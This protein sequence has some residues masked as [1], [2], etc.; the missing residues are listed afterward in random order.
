MPTR[1]RCQRVLQIAVTAIILFA[2]ARPGTALTAES[3]QIVGSGLELNVASLASNVVFVD[4]MKQATPWMS[5]APLHLDVNGN[6]MALKMGQVADTAIYST[7]PYPPGDYTLLYNGTGSFAVSSLSG[8]IVS[9]QPGRLTIRVVPKL[10]YGIRLQLTATDPRHYPTNI[11]LILPGYAMTYGQSPFYAAFLRGLR[12]F[13]VLRFKQWM[14]P[15]P[16]AGRTWETRITS[17]SFTQAGPGGASVEAMVSLANATGAN[18]WFTLPVDASDEYVFRFAQSVERGLDPRLRPIFEYGNEVWKAG[19][20][21]NVYAMTAGSHLGFAADPRRAA[22]QWYAN[23]S[24]RVFALVGSAAPRAL[25]ILSGPVAT[26]GTDNASAA[27]GILAAADTVRHADAFAIDAGAAPSALLNFPA[28][29]SLAA[30]GVLAERLHLTLISYAAGAPSATLLAAWRGA[31]GGLLITDAQPAVLPPAAYAYALEQLRPYGSVANTIG[32]GTVTRPRFIAAALPNRNEPPSFRLPAVG[33]PQRTSKLPGSLLL[34]EG[35]GGSS[36]A[37][38]AWFGAADACLTAGTA[39]TPPSSVRPCNGAAARD[40]DG[41]GALQLTPDAM[42]RRGLIVYRVPL[43]TARGLSVTFTDYAFGRVVGGSGDVSLFLADASQLMPTTLSAS[44]A[45]LPNAY[46][47]I[48]LDEN[49]MLAVRG[50]AAA[51][52]PRLG[53][54]IDAAGRAAPIPLVAAAA[55]TRS[56]PAGARTVRAELRPDGE[57]TVALDRHDGRGFIAYYRRVLSMAANG[58]PHP[59]AA[60]FLALAATTGA[61]P[62]RHQVGA[63]TVSTLTAATTFDP[64]QIKNLAAW[65]DASNAASISQATPGAVA[66]WSDLSGNGNT[67]GQSAASLQPSYSSAGINGVGSV[68]FNGNAWLLGSNA[69]FSSNVFNETTIFVVSSQTT[70]VNGSILQSGTTAHTSFGTSSTPSSR[71]VF[72]FNARSSGRLQTVNALT[73]PALWTAAGSITKKSEFVR[74]NGNVLAAGPAPG[75]S[76]TGSYPF[77]VGAINTGGTHYIY[78]FKGQLGEIAVYNRFLAPA[79]S[80]EVEGY[81]ACKWGLQN[82]LPANHPYRNVC[83][84][85]GTPTSIPTPAPTGSAL[86]APPELRSAKGQLTFN[87]TAQSDPVTGNPAL[88]YNGAETPPTL[89]LMPGDTL[90]VNLTNHLPTPPPGVSY[91]NNVNLHYH[92]LHVSPNAPGDDSIDM[93]SS[94]GQSLQYKI[95]IPTNHPPGLYWY[96]THSHGE[97]ERQNLAGMSGAIVI[98]GIA[99]YAPQVAHMPERILIARDAEPSGQSLPDASTAQIDAMRWAMQH[100]TGTAASQKSPAGSSMAMSAPPMIMRNM[101]VR[102]NTTAKTRNPYVVTNP[103]YRR[104]IRPLSA[105]THCQ[106]SETPSKVWT[107]NGLSQ[108]SIGIRPG[109]SQFWR[110]VNAGADTYLDVQLDNAQMQIVALDGVPLI[111]GNN[112]PA[113]MT[114]THYVVPPASRIEF[115]VTGPSNSK[116][117]YLRTNCFDAGAEGAAMPAA[118]LASINPNHSPSDLVRRTQPIAVHAKPFRFHTAAF[119]KA[120]A[121]TATQT[122]YFSDQMTINGQSYDPAAPPLF[123]AQSGTVQEWTIINTSAQVHTFHTHQIHFVVEAIDGIT[124]AQQFVMD[125]VNVPAATSNGP[126]TVKVLLDFT[127]PL[128]IGT[129]LVHCHIGSHEDAGMMAKIRVGTARPMSVSQS[130]LTF[131]GTNAAAQSV[132]ITGGQSPYSITGCT[133]VANASI[134]GTTVSV[135]PSGVGSC[136]LT[137]SDST[138]LTAPINVTVQGAAP[139]VVA[140]PSSVSFARPTAPAQSVAISGGTA[141]YT[142][143][144]CQNI[145]TS[146]ANGSTLTLKPSGAGTCTVTVSDANNA[147]ATVSVAVANA[148]P[149]PDMDNLTFHH[150]PARTG[151]NQNEPTLTTANVGGGTFGLLTTLVAPSASPAFGKV[152]AQPLF[153]S[154]EATV[155]G[156]LHNLVVVATATD[157]LYAFD[158]Q[159]FNIV[160]QRSFTNPGASIKQ[161]SYYDTECADVAPNIGI[162]STPVI[163]RAV[164]RV[165][166]VVATDESGTSHLRLHAVSLASGAEATDSSGHQIGP[167]DITGTVPLATGGTASVDPRWNLQRPALL[168][169]SGNI[170][171]ALG[172]HCDYH[173]SSTH[174]WLLSYSAANLQMTGNLLDTTGSSDGS[175]IFLGSIWMSGYGPTADASGNVYFSTGN[176]PYDGKTNFAMSLVEVPGTL[177]VTKSSNFTPYNAAAN[178]KADADF[179][180]GGVMLLPDQTGSYAHLAFAGGKCDQGNTRCMKWLLNRDKLG[181]QQNR[182]AGAVWQGNYGGG[183]F[184]GPAYYQ[185]A[186]KTSHILFGDGASSEPFEL[187]TLGLNPVAL[188]MQS[189][190]NVGCLECRN[191]GSQPVVSSNGTVAGTAVAWALKTPTISGGTITLYA[192]DASNVATTLYSGAAGSWN[193]P[194]GHTTIGGALVSPLVADG[195]VYVPTDGGVA[196]FGLP[197]GSSTAARSKR[198]TRSHNIAIPQRIH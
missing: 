108:P 7:G 85:G 57:L 31:G 23:R 189:S 32:S 71:S 86:P 60:V 148:T 103:M 150:D 77:V 95:A 26:P 45:L 194:S 140:S 122:V 111:A 107:L 161:Q 24:D 142:A 105:D 50:A 187:S 11:R 144:S 98:E 97:T 163:D 3:Q 166:V 178:S 181:G 15:Q 65:Y 55:G 116:A 88:S 177:D 119:I 173:A 40:A 170:Y 49:G 167:V 196:V 132:T 191:A 64:T 74:R 115:V 151:W 84:Q 118:I 128:V 136:Q 75:V 137:V 79:E 28:S 39:F 130:Q 42:D 87:V 197:S 27:A 153:A 158:D 21:S 46:A 172:S 146:T 91:L 135:T 66:S 155:D 56:R 9:R 123:Y 112:T 96:H 43:P 22:L 5:S 47:S 134:S 100:A 48:D 44:S 179:G 164:D 36:T 131:S 1:L 110:L 10:G 18:P 188:K 52:Y 25:H 82:R 147:T 104:F 121:V 68:S 61:T 127:D 192:F 159:T 101:A 162:M 54:A 183:M 16:Y 69:S 168:E 106:G 80:A 37:A 34:S 17:A 59:P 190:A 76:A 33:I 30:S 90:T 186:S 13:S 58:Q 195:H 53:G 81:L 198:T 70:P 78:S 120:H 38:H 143:T 184:G 138:G 4:A 72:D 154:G 93:V 102:G 94:P 109:E 160:W 175:N 35:F 41:S 92:G 67:L 133:N 180:S 114:V 117:A 6:V 193:P 182:D 129:F 185:D 149:T 156:N 20:P 124:Q 174:G 12:P 29:D 2:L 126:G 165:Y 113:S 73:G 152:Y 169:S 14:K 171:V 157:Q 62:G 19:T 51:G 83:P 176:G 125:N 8:R 99:Q 145:V 139:T 141:P 89:R 63:L